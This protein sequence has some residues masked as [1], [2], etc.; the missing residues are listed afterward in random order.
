MK[1]LMN[2]RTYGLNFKFF[3]SSVLQF[4]SSSVCI[5]C[6]LFFIF[7]IN[8]ASGASITGLIQNANQYDGQ[9]VEIQA[10]VIGDVMRRSN[11][12]WLNVS[13]GTSAIGIFC[14][15]SIL[16]QIKFRGDYKNSGDILLIKGQFN[17][18]DRS[19]GGDLDIRASEIKVIKDGYKVKRE[20]NRGKLNAIV[21]L[22]PIIIVLIIIKP[23]G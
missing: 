9:I 13:D 20:L 16:P 5:L 23:R 21:I 7:D 10:E 18:A 17:R 6:L 4:F 3:S 8:P 15:R 2:E 12:V 19:Q 1:I 11:G 14:A 22:V